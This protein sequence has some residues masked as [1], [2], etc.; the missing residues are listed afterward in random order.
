MAVV[1]YFRK[2]LELSSCH[3]WSGPQQVLVRDNTTTLHARGR[4]TGDGD[5]ELLRVS[6]QVK[7]TPLISQY[8][9]EA[10]R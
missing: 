9:H 1:E 5:R 8:D 7:T 4:V 6:Y 2:A 3:T 10:L